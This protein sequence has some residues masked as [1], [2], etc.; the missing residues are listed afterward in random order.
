MCLRWPMARVLMKGAAGVADG[1]GASSAS[2]LRAHKHAGRVQAA[3]SLAAGGATVSGRAVV[4]MAGRPGAKGAG[5]VEQDGEGRLGL[6]EIRPKAS[7]MGSGSGPVLKCGFTG[8]SR[9]AISALLTSAAAGAGEPLASDSTQ[10]AHHIQAKACAYSVR[11]APYTLRTGHA[12]P[13]TAVAAASPATPASR[14][15][16]A[17]C[18]ALEQWPQCAVAAQFAA[19]APRPSQRRLRSLCIVTIGDSAPQRIGDCPPM[20]CIV[21]PPETSPAPRP[22]L[23]GRDRGL[24]LIRH[25]RER[26]TKGINRRLPPR[27]GIDNAERVLPATSLAAKPA[28][29]PAGLSGRPWYI[30]AY[31]GRGRSVGTVGVHQSICVFIHRLPAAGDA[32]RLTATLA[33]S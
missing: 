29:L 30:Q 2:S 12:V 33:A 21:P 13:S 6:N 26:Q 4:A 11:S 17:R 14:A 10:R 27:E 32:A 15:P 20:R 23:I 3:T 5:V 16:S 31:R 22:E 1:A 28:C 9:G 7:S 24:P 18:S 19:A 8:K 25:E